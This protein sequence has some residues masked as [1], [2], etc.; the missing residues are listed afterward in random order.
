MSDPVSETTKYRRDWYRIC[1]ERVDM[2]GRMCGRCEYFDLGSMDAGGES[3]CLNRRAPRF[4]THA[5]Q[6]CIN[7]VEGT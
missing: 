6:T 3:D 4:Q 1:G 2:S 5:T 7:W